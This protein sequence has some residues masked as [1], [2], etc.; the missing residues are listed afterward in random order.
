MH[1]ACAQIELLD[2]SEDRSVCFKFMMQTSR[3][4]MTPMLF[5]RPISHGI[6]CEAFRC[7]IWKGLDACLM[8]ARG[9]GGYGLG[10][11]ILSYEKGDNIDY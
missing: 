7:K 3:G 8:R 5:N 11:G 10:R 4:V 6:D 1:C 2:E 9:V